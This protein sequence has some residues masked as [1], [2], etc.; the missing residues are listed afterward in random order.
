MGA[1]AVRVAGLWGVLGAL[2]LS[3]CGGDINDAAGGVCPAGGTIY[4]ECPG[5]MPSVATCRGDASGYDP[6]ACPAGSGGQMILSTGASSSSG[7]AQGSGAMGATGGL[8]GSGGD[9]TGGDGTGGAGTG[10]DGSGGAGNPADDLDALRETCLDH[11]NMYR[12]TLGVPALVRGSATQE[13]CSDDGAQ[14]DS[15]SGMAHQSAG[16]CQG[17]GAQNTCPG[18]PAQGG[19]VAGALTGC[20]DQMWAEGPPPVPVDECIQDYVGCFLKHG[21]YINMSAAQTSV[22]SCGFYQQGDG[23]WWMNQDFGG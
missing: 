7:G 5:G 6:C 22:V 2:W 18:W 20:L 16:N 9:G 4:C 1:T 3:G 13:S 21:H 23:K 19:D 17:L 8:L 12:A 14:S 15:L 11:I 10:G